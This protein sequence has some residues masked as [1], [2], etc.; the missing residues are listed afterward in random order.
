[1]D[2]GVPLKDAVAGIAMGLVKEG[3]RF[4]VLTDIAGAEDHHG[5]MDFKVAGTR[6]GITGLQMDIK[7]GGIT[8][9]IMSRALAQAHRA[10]LSILDTM[11][12]ALAKPRPDISPYA[13]RILTITVNKDKIRDI[14]GPGGK[15]I[16][17]IIE[18]TGCKIEVHDDGRVDI[19]SSDEAAA[20][21]AV[22]IIKELTAEAELG[23]TYVGK[24]V[25]V[26]N[27]GAF[28]EILPGV[29]GLLHISEIANR[30]IAEVRDEIDEGDEVL[31]KVIDIDGMGRVRLSRRALL[32]EEGGEPRREPASVGGPRPG[33]GGPPRPSRQGQRHGGG[34]RGPGGG[35]RRP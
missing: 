11:A 1:M 2:A 34:H 4:A 33:R 28:V 31:V 22:E 14:I 15:M 23:K 6:A 12:Q 17:S 25:R 19:A 10:R 9:E 24:V 32:R 16:R 7:I 8:R 20:R 3:D 35:G 26:V 13:P 30:R 5:D 29:E 21:K 27:F 18:R